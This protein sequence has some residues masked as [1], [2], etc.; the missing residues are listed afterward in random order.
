[1]S[2]LAAALHGLGLRP[3]ERVAVLSETGSLELEAGIQAALPRSEPARRSF[4]DF[5][6]GGDG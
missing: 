3:G 1:M 2:D 5:V 6:A 4:A